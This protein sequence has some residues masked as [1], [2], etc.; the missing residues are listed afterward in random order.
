MTITGPMTKREQVSTQTTRGGITGPMTGT[1]QYKS[2]VSQPTQT[3]Q[4]QPQNIVVPESPNP[5]QTMGQMAQSV[6]GGIKDFAGKIIS[7]Q[8]VVSPDIQTQVSKLK[9]EQIKKLPSL[10]V[11]DILPG[12]KP[13]LVSGASA[14]LKPGDLSKG[15]FSKEA[16][17]KGVKTVIDSLPPVSATNIAKGFFGQKIALVQS[18]GGQNWEGT[19]TVF[20]P[21]NSGEV[22]GKL[23][24]DLIEGYYAAKASGINAPIEQ[25]GQELKQ[26]LGASPKFARLLDS[27]DRFAKVRLGTVLNGLKADGVT[28][29]DIAAVRNGTATAE[30]VA[31]VKV[32]PGETQA[33][34][35][36]MGL[37]DASPKTTLYNFIRQK[38]RQ[39]EAAL[40]KAPA[41]TGET[42][43][44][45]GEVSPGPIPAMSIPKDTSMYSNSLLQTGVGTSDQKIYL[46][47]K[48]I[49]VQLKELDRLG[50]TTKYGLHLTAPGISGELPT[51]VEK[52]K[53]QGTPLVGI[54]DQA[55]LPDEL[56]NIKPTQPK[57]VGGEGINPLIAEAKKYGS[58]EEFVKAQ[59]V[60]AQL[61][62]DGTKINPDGTVTLYHVT[63]PEI[64]S[65][66]KKE[67]LFRGAPAPVGGMTGVNI[68]KATF[69]GTDKKW[70]KDTWGSG[71]EAMIEVKVPAE[72]IRK[73]AQNKLEVYFEDGLK[74]QGD[75]WVPT[76][77]PQSTFYDRIAEKHLVDSKQLTDIYNQPKGV[78][79]VRPEIKSKEI[80]APKETP[81]FQSRVFERMKEEYPQLKGD[82]AYDPTTLKEEAT[83][84]VD[85]IAAD[86]EKA[87]RLAMGAEASKDVTSTSV[88]IAMAEKALES[89]NNSL[90]ARLVKTRSFEQTRR[91]QEI[92]SEKQSISN[93]STSKYVKELVAS[94]LEVLGKKYLSGLRGK[95]N[96]DVGIKAID[97]EVAKTQSRIKNKEMDIKEA[98]SLLDRLTCK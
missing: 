62:E 10:K 72:Y 3:P 24:H 32:I 60:K 73:G 70:V 11:G 39:V 30:Q 37:R 68:E 12:F 22:A 53:Q 91:G 75:V 52:F 83:K 85:L 50:V 66:I 77:P 34:I 43:L 28:V 47:P 4:Y 48:E 19:P 64:A 9:P 88:N 14:T 57:G 54:F 25:G 44:L 80:T 84:A 74:K 98:Q 7:P 56:K 69:F 63:T 65:K 33:E 38:I 41:E 95:S 31:K 78:A 6:V 5:L 46:V 76:K 1:S 87:F 51:K 16:A 40:K 58:A 97:R 92:V 17:T 90:F 36:R 15:V 82:L 93:N 96:K 21:K 81:E 71:R 86:K 35:A 8:P 18:A 49:E 94:R 29:G 67:G 45:T 26:V 79:E 89:G 13:E 59:G 20:T 55:M 23:L 61:L 2:Q 42:K 27:I